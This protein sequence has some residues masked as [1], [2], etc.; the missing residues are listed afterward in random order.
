MPKASGIARLWRKNMLNKSGMSDDEDEIPH[1]I[2]LSPKQMMWGG[3][4]YAAGSLGYSI[5]Q[6]A[7]ADLSGGKAVTA[8]ALSCAACIIVP[9][10]AGLVGN[11]LGRAGGALIGAVAQVG[12]AFTPAEK[13]RNFRRN[14][15]MFGKTLGLA[16]GVTVGILGAHEGIGHMVGT[17][18][19]YHGQLPKGPFADARPGRDDKTTTAFYPVLS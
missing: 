16:A 18:K 19:D 7:Q 9:F 1:G 13:R 14:A 12:Y 10:V 2:N 8:T 17:V 6:A 5:Y 4:G 11:Q 15:I 3:I